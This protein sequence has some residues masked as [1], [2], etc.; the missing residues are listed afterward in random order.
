MVGLLDYKYTKAVF[1]KVSGEKI[2][3]IPQSRE[4]V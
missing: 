2:D 3:G 1:G 4:G